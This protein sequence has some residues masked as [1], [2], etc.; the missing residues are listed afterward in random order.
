MAAPYRYRP[1]VIEFL[2]T[3]GLRPTPLTPPEIVREA[4]SDMYRFEINRLKA[5][6]KRGEFPKRAYASRVEALRNEYPLL[7]IDIRHWLE[8]S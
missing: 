6:L 2:I 7:G 5:Q 8:N 3:R 4:L 1:I